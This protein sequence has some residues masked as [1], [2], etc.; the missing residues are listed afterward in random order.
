MKKELSF[1]LT[2]FAV[3][4]SM[5]PVTMPLIGESLPTYRYEVDLTKVVKDRIKVNLDCRDFAAEHLI[6]HFPKI[7]PGTYMV[8]N[9]G[10]YIKDFSVLDENGNQLPVKKTGKNTYLIS[11]ASQL[12]NIS[13]WVN[14]TWDAKPFWSRP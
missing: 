13:Y 8:A 12:D 9:F 3:L 5:F 1:V 7:I 10:K 14:D 2:C 4:L 11:K 6:Y